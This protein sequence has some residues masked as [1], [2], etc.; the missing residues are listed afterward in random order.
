[1]VENLEPLEGLGLS[2]W[3]DDGTGHAVFRLTT[4]D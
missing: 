3:N 4:N 2:S 1:V